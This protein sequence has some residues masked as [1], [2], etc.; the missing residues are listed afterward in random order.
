MKL[1][2]FVFSTTSEPSRDAAVIDD[3]LE[4]DRLSEELGM[5]AIWMAEHHFDGMGA[6]A[7]PVVFAAAIAT[8]T[9]RAQIGFAVVQASLHH[10]L[11]LAE[12]ISLFDHLIGAQHHR[13]RECDAEGLGNFEVDYHLELGRLLDRQ[14]GGLLALEDA[15]GIEACSVIQVREVESVAHQAACLDKATVMARDW[16]YM[17]AARVAICALRLEKN[18]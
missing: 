5:D 2:T 12:Q 1:G 18:G 14:I 9:E 15:P 7:D 8:A 17:V 6:Y 13:R 4:E 10:P 11:R 16:K 3:A